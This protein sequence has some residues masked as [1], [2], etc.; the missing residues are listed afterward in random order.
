MKDLLKL[1]GLAV[2]LFVA[3]AAWNLTGKMD[4]RNVDTVV[5]GGVLVAVMFF[6]VL[7]LLIFG[8]LIVLVLRVSRE[9]DGGGGR[10]R[11]FMPAPMYRPLPHPEGSRQQQGRAQLAPPPWMDAPPMLEG[12]AEPGSWQ[13][14]G[15]GNY[16][17]WNGQAIDGE[18]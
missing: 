15:G 17:T 8:L 4:A 11:D 13:N 1:V 18:W 9:R 3:V 16:D 14:S 2:V 5:N 6:G 10:G 7:A 12:K